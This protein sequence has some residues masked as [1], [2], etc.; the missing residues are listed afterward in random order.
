M[1]RRFGLLI[2]LPGVILLGFGLRAIEQDR[3]ATDQEVRDRLTRAAELA[4]RT[5]NQQLANWQQFRSDGVVID[6]GPPRKVKPWSRMAYDPVKR[7]EPIQAVD[8]I[9]TAAINAEQ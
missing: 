5:I 4:A 8:P 6:S 9:L 7:I 3:G 1:L 2:I